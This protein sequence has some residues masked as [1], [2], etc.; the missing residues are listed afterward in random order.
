MKIDSEDID[1][2]NLFAKGY[3]HIPRFQR[4]Y[5]WDGENISDLWNDI[6]NAANDEYFIGSMVVYRQGKMNYYIV[7]GQQRLTTI[8]ILLCAIRDSLAAVDQNNLA[9]G[10]H[11]LI[12]RANRDNENEYTLQTETSF[13]YLQEHIQKFGPPDTIETSIASEEEALAAAYKLL[14][15]KIDEGLKKVADSHDSEENNRRKSEYLIKLRDAVFNLKIILVQLE[16]EEDAYLIFETL[17]TRGKDL[18][19]TDLL[20]NL[21]TKLIRKTSSVDSAKLKWNTIL[22]TIHSSSADLT[23]DTFVFHYW[24]SRYDSTPSK[25]LYAAFAKKVNKE[26]AQTFLDELQQDSQ[27]Y[28]DIH[29]PS[30]R[31]DKHQTKIIRSLEALQTFRVVQPT[32]ALL[33]LVRA[34]RNDVIREAT[35]ARALQAIEKFHFSFTA[36]TSSRSSGGIAGMYS[37]FARRLSECGDSNAAGM[38][39]NLLIKK[40]RE[41]VPEES[42]FLVGFQALRYTN[43]L[44]KQ[45]SLV[46]YILMAF[47]EHEEFKFR[48]IDSPLTIEHI[49]PQSWIGQADWD[50]A[51]IAAMGNLFLMDK[52]S[53]D[54]AANMS[55]AAKL[56]FFKSASVSYPNYL[57]SVIAWTPETIHERTKKMASDAYSTIWKI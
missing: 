53:N 9:Q 7:D 11:Q 55:F 45:K 25:K 22:D 2:E 31:W 43:S 29:E 48:S 35:L 3:F 41:R 5:S 54:D 50:E 1:L 28:R 33:S 13:P 52:Q 19:I 56:E 17:N 21:F 8:V 23:P 42:E 24:A 12:E 49:A 30:T 57:D 6:Q 10:V 38:E 4:P 44:T 37:A 14:T 36:I 18:A 32:P 34:F 47:A 20:K 39:I 15:S 51:P 40:L 27:Y 26:N 16:N 46:R